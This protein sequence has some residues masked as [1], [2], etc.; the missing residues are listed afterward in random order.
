MSVN[1]QKSAD[2]PTPQAMAGFTAPLGLVDHL[3]RPKMKLDLVP[4]LDLI[5]IGLMISL[6]FTRFVMVP[7]VRVDLPDSEQRM[8]H[9]DAAVAVLTIGN[10]GMLYFDGSVYEQNSIER[11]FQRHLADVDNAKGSVLLVK[12]EGS[13]QLQVFLDLCRMAQE[14]GF[15]QVQLAGEK[16][17]VPSALIPPGSVGDS[18][19]F[20]IPVM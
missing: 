20:S 12:T 13:M 1:S 17:T 7:G 9:H 8:P 6:L 5:T 14:A 11:A 16:K 10:K 4:V 3:H 18:Q 19:Q 2:D 15:Q